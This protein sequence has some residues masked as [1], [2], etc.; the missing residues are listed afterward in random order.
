VEFQDQWHQPIKKP[1]LS[2]KT[3][4][5]LG[6]SGWKAYT[7]KLI[8]SHSGWRKV[9]GSS[10]QSTN[11]QVNVGDLQLAAS[12]AYLYCTEV[13]ETQSIQQPTIALAFD[14]RPTSPLLAEACCFGLLA[15]N[16]QLHF[17]GLLPIPHLAAHVQRQA[18]LHGFIYISAS[19][20][21]VGYNGF[22]FGMA[23]GMVLEPQLVLDL[24]KEFRDLAN[25]PI[26]QANILQKIS[27]V[28][29][30]IIQQAYRLV[31]Q[32]RKDS[33]NDYAALF[34]LILHGQEKLPPNLFKGANGVVADL[35]GSARCVSLDRDALTVLGLKT[36]FINTKPGQF[37]HEIL[38]EG[39]SL[40]PCAKELANHPDCNLGYVPDCDGDRGN[41]VIRKK[42]T[43]QIQA[44]EAQELFALCVLSELAQMIDQ[45][46]LT[47][48]SDDY[49]QERVAIVANDPTS[50]RIDRIVACFKVPVFRAEVG[51]A[52]LNALAQQLRN[53]GW[54]VRLVG[55]GSN[56]G[57]ITYPGTV[58]DPLSTLASVLR[59]LCQPRLFQIWCERS[60]QPYDATKNY[61]LDDILE[62]LP[63]FTTTPVGSPR[64]VLSV[65]ALP[66]ARFKALFETYFITHGWNSQKDYL[67]ENLDIWGWEE[68]NYEGPE[69]RRG[70]GPPFRSGKETGGLKILLKNRKGQDKGFLWMRG[71]GTEPVL[72]VMVDIE[73][74]SSMHEEYLMNWFTGMLKK[75]T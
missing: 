72:R 23:N 64:A 70:F 36:Y 18:Q 39:E 61:A 19:H 24:I 71:S 15:A 41:I 53:Q 14:S 58:R 21:P 45:G 48:D 8:L 17:L 66:Q 62:T 47:Y 54:F 26:E 68:V 40:I 16:A 59:L 37:T 65:P 52:N 1:Q 32:T 13:F 22:K 75:I 27:E 25:N 73:G 69:E 5:P 2:S 7:E 35:N 4:K 42:E 49:P 51:E 30:K 9:F 67:A 6:E 34:S 20:N 46:L 56:G 74:T 31:A 60:N 57:N 3:W 55:E 50:L 29:P 11:S 44:L 12:A 63:K 28:D 10:E 33:F 38:P 43:K